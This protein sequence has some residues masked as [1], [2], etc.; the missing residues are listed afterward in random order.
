MLTL[1]Y[2]RVSVERVLASADK[3][4]AVAG[5]CGEHKGGAQKAGESRG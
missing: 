4:R 5:R 2:Q 3:H 1:S